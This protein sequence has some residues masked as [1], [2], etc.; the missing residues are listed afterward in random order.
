MTLEW[1]LLVPLDQINIII[2]RVVCDQ[3]VRGFECVDHTLDV[4][5]KLNNIPVIIAQA[6]HVSIPPNPP[7]SCCKE[8]REKTHQAILEQI[9]SNI[10][11]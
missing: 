3:R 11:C 10:I 7:Y 6:R 2:H 1:L 9:M 8:E 4:E 5:G